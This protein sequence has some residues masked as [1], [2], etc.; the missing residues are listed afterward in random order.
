M[1]K[2]PTIISAST[3]VKGRVQGQEDIDVLGCVEGQIE[4]EGQLSIDA[5]AR[6]DADVIATV[7]TVQGILVGDTSAS[8]SIY[9]ESSARVVGNLSAPSIV[10]EDGAK[11]RG[12][13]ETGEN[14]GTTKSR[15]KRAAAPAAKR[16]PAKRS[17][18]PSPEPEDI[19]DD[20]DDEPELP[21]GARKKKVAIKK[22][23]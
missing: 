23:G 10:I 1:S 11:V 20:S 6:V 17:R 12:Q 4:I 3:S 21:A 13:V 14:T 5:D 15:P 22:R 2:S 8:Q 16:T 7:V 19:D 9:L 18:T